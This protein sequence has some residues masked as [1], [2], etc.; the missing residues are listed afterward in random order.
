MNL[1]ESG[2]RIA[3]LRKAAGY[4]QKTL[5]YALSITDKAVSKWERGICMPDS[6]ILPKLASLLDTDLG[7]LLSNDGLLTDWKGILITDGFSVSIDTLINGRPLIHY[8]MSYFL[9]LKITDVAIITKDEEYVRSL[10][11]H[12]YGLNISFS[13]FYSEKTVIVDGEFLLFGAYL[14][15]QLLTMMLSN[16]DT[17]PCINGTDLPVLIMHKKS[18]NIGELFAVAKR[19]S[20]FRGTIFIPIRTTENICDVESLIRIYE[21]YHGIVFSDLKEIAQNRGIVICN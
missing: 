11:L 9:L 3:A 5:A 13:P 8:L 16:E 12:Q 14:S 20:L 18:D 10:N 21:K 15:T 17:V 19:K 2:K 4:T 1:I 7:T 6:V